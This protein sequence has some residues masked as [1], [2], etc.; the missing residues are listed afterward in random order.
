MKKI[1]VFGGTRF[2]G[3]KL[4]EYLIAEGHEVTIATRGKTEH[5]FGEKVNHSIVDRT[6][7]DDLASAFAN[8]QWDIIYDNICYSPNDALAACEIFDGKTKKYVFTSTMSTYTD[9]GADLS[10]ADFD[11][12]TYEIRFGND[13]D[14]SYGEGKRLAEAVFFQKATFPVVAVRFPIVL[15]EDDYTRRLHFHVER[16]SEEKVISFLNMD[17]RMSYILSD[18]AGDFLKFAGFS[19][20][21]GPYN[22]TSSGTYSL[23]ELMR[24]IEQNVGKKA[25]IALVGDEETRSPFAVPKDW[26]MS[27]E[28]SIEAGFTCRPLEN[29]L[30]NLI[31]TLSQQIK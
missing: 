27:Q 10:E 2:F 5:S 31:K 17:A 7:K 8:A 1:L 12:Y 19:D 24:M 20:I 30:P 26:F 25:K 9:L 11:P 6:N 18:D 22:A 29:W 21:V 23:K 4:V 28:K 16:V 13:G 14:Y 15:G 3:K